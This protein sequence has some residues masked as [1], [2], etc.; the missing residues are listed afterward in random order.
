MWIY[1]LEKMMVAGKDD[2]EPLRPIVFAILVALNE[3]SMHGYGIMKVVNERMRRRALLGPGTL[4]RTLKEL[5]DDGLIEYA[6]APRDADARRRYYRITAE[7]R[8][9]A[10]AEAARMADWVDMARR[11]RLLQGRGAQ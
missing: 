1:L 7:G 6:P 3:R 4:Y 8:Q 5:R 9:I 11:G 2:L 10:R